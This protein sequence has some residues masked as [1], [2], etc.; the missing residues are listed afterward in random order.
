MNANER[1]FIFKKIRV[2]LRS[3]AANYSGANDL[4]G[5]I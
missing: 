2:Y 1:G 3:S 5:I 4:L